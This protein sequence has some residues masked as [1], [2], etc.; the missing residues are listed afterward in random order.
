MCL[1][2]YAEH[3]GVGGGDNDE[4]GGVEN[5]EYADGVRPTGRL[6]ACDVQ[7]QTNPGAAVEVGEVVDAGEWRGRQRQCHAPQEEHGDSSFAHAQALHAQ[8]EDDGNEAV[9]GDERKCEDAQ[10]AREGRQ[11]AGELAQDAV[12]P[13][14]VVDDVMAAVGDVDTG[15]D[16]QVDPHEQVAQSQVRDEERVNLSW[17]NRCVNIVSSR[18][19][20]NMLTLNSGC[21]KYFPNRTSTP[22]TSQDNPKHIAK[23]EVI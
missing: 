19:Q 6:V 13:H 15:D 2:R 7:R 22:N 17:E 5:D 21:A 9:D 20:W 23:H 11:E 16:E 1:A 3:A 4:G 8:W 18:E 10:L 14:Q 12:T